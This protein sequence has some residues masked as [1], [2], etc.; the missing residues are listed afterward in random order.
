LENGAGLEAVSDSLDSNADVLLFDLPGGKS[1]DLKEV[2]GKLG[3]LIAEMTSANY[4]IVVVLAMSYLKA[5]ALEVAEVVK[6]WGQGVQYVAVLNLGMAERDQFIFFDGERSEQCGH[7][8]QVLANA[9]GVVIEMP[10]LQAS[11]YAELDADEVP[12]Y[13]AASDHEGYKRMTRVRIR[14][15]LELMDSEIAKIGL[16]H[17][18]KAALAA[19]AEAQSKKATGH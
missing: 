9:G 6:L 13:K 1:D 17:Y 19:F 10:K 7:P 4:E 12:F 3:T 16:M 18:P 15:W 8:A 2:F 14:E 11:T 5:S